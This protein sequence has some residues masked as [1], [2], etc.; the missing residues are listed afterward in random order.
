MASLLMISSIIS[1]FLYG[2]C[3]ANSETYKRVFKIPNKVFDG[4]S[5][6]ILS[7]LKQIFDIDQKKK[8]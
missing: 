7:F 3:F 5:T 8:K 2:S 4:V 1:V 6:V